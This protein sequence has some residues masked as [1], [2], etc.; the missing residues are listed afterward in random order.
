[1]FELIVFSATPQFSCMNCSF[2]VIVLY[3]NVFPLHQLSSAGFKFLNLPNCFVF[4]RWWMGVFVRSCRNI[5]FPGT[6]ALVIIQPEPSYSFYLTI[7]SIELV[8]ELVP[9]YSFYLTIWSIELVK[10]LVPGSVVKKEF[11]FWGQCQ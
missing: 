6:I 7:W 2:S 10:E 9:S 3:L 11:H 5:S 8:K 4:H 1:L